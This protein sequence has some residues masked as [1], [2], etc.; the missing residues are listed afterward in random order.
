M[1]MSSFFMNQA[2]H[3]LEPK[4]PPTEEYSQNNYM[5]SHGHALATEDYCQEPVPHGYHGYAPDHRRY[6]QD[7]YMHNGGGAGGGGQTGYG[8]CVAPAPPGG[9]LPPPPSQDAPSPPHTAAGYPV[10]SENS[11]TLPSPTQQANGS[12]GEQKPGQIIYPWM[13]KVHMGSSG[14]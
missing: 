1:I 4:F 14:T 11:P 5:H 10:T 6:A 13:K 2:G 9:A 7:S 3:Y 12:D 8:A